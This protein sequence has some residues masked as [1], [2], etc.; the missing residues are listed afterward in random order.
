[1]N[2]LSTFLLP[3]LVGAL[4]CAST[5]PEQTRQ[6][7]T[8]PSGAPAAPA[9]GGG[10]APVAVGDPTLHA[11]CSA[12]VASP[13]VIDSPEAGAGRPVVIHVG[14]V[15][16]MGPDANGVWRAAGHFDAETPHLEISMAVEG[17]MTLLTVKNAT[18][19]SLRYRAA[20]KVPGHPGWLRTSVVPL[21]P[22]IRGIETW[23]HP[24][25]ALAIFG[26]EFASPSGD[27]QRVI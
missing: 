26:I 24:I 16:C 9:P 23:P 22:Y 1:M 20:M 27:S 18:P 15:I 14:D 4:G 11:P 6:S 12:S 5:A 8:V 25:E 10:Q 19:K 21:L 7:P 13:E 2:R 17:R 3:V